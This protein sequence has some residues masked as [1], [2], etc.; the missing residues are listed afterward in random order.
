MIDRGWPYQVVLEARL[1]MGDRFYTVH[2]FCDG[3]GLSLCPRGHYFHANKRDHNVYCFSEQA[4]A[5]TF[6]QRFG[7]EFVDARGQPGWWRKRFG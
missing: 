4:H 2:Y 3:E 1:S 7:G 5:E 6:Q